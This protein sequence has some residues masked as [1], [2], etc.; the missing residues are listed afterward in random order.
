MKLEAGIPMVE[1]IFDI[2]CSKGNLTEQEILI[3]EDYNELKKINDDYNELMEL[4]KVRVFK[5]QRE[6][7][8]PDFVK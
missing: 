6:I 5:Q 7:H 4:N 2:L 8:I 3:L 1:E